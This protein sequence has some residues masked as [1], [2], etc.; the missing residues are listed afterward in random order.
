MIKGLEIGIF[1][2]MLLI[3]IV[4]L[5]AV[6]VTKNKDISSKVKN[7]NKIKSNFLRAI[8]YLFFLGVIFLLGYISKHL[9]Y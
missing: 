6:L 2:L 5:L 3:P 8:K 9:F 1:I 7:G 4:L